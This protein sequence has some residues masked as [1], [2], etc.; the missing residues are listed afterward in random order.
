MAFTFDTATNLGKVRLLIGDMV[1]T[2]HQFEDADINN[3]ISFNGTDLYSTAAELLRSLA[4][5]RSLLAKKKAAGGYS[6]DLTEIAKEL[7]STANAYETK[8]RSIPADAQAEQIFTDFNY[9]DIVTRKALRSE[10][11]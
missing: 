6:E 9:S 7:R 5:N 4:A 11:D 3:I 8:A 2:G 10:S 1:D